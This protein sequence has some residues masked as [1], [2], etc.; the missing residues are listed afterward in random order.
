MW[1]R[2]WTRVL[3]VAC[4]TAFAAS[5]VEPAMHVPWC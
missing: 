1:E 2:R 5:L 4:A 3:S